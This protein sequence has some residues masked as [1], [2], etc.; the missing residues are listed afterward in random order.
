VRVRGCGCMRGIWCHALMHVP[1]MWPT[2]LQVVE[3]VRLQAE[4]LLPLVRITLSTLGIDELRLLQV[5]AIGTEELT[6]QS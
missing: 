4:L 3:R 5:E 1:A 6:N 2:A